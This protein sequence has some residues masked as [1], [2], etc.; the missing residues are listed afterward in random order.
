MLTPP[1]CLTCGFSDLGLS[2]SATRRSPHSSRRVPHTSRRGAASAPGTGSGF[3]RGTYPRNFS[4]PRPTAN[5]SLCDSMR[6]HG[7]SE[8]KACW[9]PETGSLPLLKIGTGQQLW[10]KRSILRL[11]STVCSPRPPTILQRRKQV[12]CARPRRDRTSVPQS[13]FQ[14]PKFCQAPNHLIFNKANAIDVALYM[15]K[16]TKI[17]LRAQRGKSRHSAQQHL[18]KLQQPSRH[19]P[20]QAR[21]TNP[22]AR[23]NGPGPKKT[24]SKKPQQNQ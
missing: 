18:L 20:K 13:R 21:H 10:R 16:L 1:P 11:T 5:R 6:S 7:S 23:R 12:K 4:N 14:P 2:K 22:S 15:S 19:T 24:I 8:T 3:L 9:F 17:E